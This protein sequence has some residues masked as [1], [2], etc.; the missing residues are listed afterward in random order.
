MQTPLKSNPYIMKYAN[1]PAR[2]AKVM[3]PVMCAAAPVEDAGEPEAVPEG[4]DEEPELSVRLP[5]E[6]AL[7]VGETLLSAEAE[8]FL[9]AARVLGP[10]AL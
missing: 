6:P 7:M 10:L 3:L 1:A 4:D 9:K 8:A 5:P 2:P